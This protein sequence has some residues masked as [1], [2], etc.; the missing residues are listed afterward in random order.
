MGHVD[1]RRF[2][3]AW[4]GNRASISIPMP[5]SAVHPRMGGEQ[6]FFT[7]QMT[8]YTGSSPHGRGTDCPYILLLILPRFIPAWA[9][10]SRKPYVCWPD[11]PVHPR[12]G[13]EQTSCNHK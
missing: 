11:R 9:G 1:S 8:D 6:P 7:R 5:P 3:P 12:M 13:G 2:I 4:A 10:N